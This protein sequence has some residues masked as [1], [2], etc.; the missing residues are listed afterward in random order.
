MSTASRLIQWVQKNPLLLI[1]FNEDLSTQLLNSW[2]GF[3]RLTMA[4]HHST[5]HDVSLPTPCLLE[6]YKDN[7]PKCYLATA[8]RKTAISTF[9]SRL[10][11]KKLRE[12]H[13]DY[14][15]A[16][17]ELISESR[18]QHMLS[19]HLSEEN[20]IIK[21]S[22]ELSAHLIEILAK[23]PENQS[24]L[25]TALFLLSRLEEE[26]LNFWAQEDAIQSALAVFGIR[27][28]AI[29]DD[30]VLKKDTFSGLKF[31]G[32]HI[33]ED[34]IVHLD[35]TQ[36]P[37][38]EKISD[39]VT[40]RAIFQKGDERL[41]IYTANKLPLEEMLGVDLIYINETRGNIVMI[42]YKMLEEHIHNN[43]SRDWIFRPDKQ[44]YSEISHMQLPDVN[45]PLNDYRMN[46]NPFFFKFVKRKIEGNK[47]QSIFISIDH[48][49]QLLNSP[50][51]RGP[52]NGIR[53][54][55]NALN[56]IYLREADMLS[57]I[58]SGYIGTYKI[59]T[60]ALKIIINEAA[61]G[62]KAI[63]LGWQKKIQENTDE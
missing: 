60:E 3:E 46:R 33:Y 56:G 7:F 9:D 51:S 58:R 2:S 20:E 35:A 16:F 13:P 15:H 39:D 54:S 23:N 42:Q 10:T 24:A 4:R 52:R 36:L 19:Q 6:I 34:N 22:P 37:G 50:D 41:V 5:F 14:L 8:I 55:Y 31:T 17:V 40:A 43:D 30:V 47:P 32:M 18:M 28:E 53:I 49:K 1:R 25:E 21:L 44:L 59:E 26:S 57:L 61:R 38:F 29:P 27:G 12:I 62:N 45:E 48:L 11:I 63:V